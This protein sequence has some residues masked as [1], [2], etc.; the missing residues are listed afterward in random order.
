MSIKD[1]FDEFQDL[2]KKMSKQFEDA[3]RWWED[4]E[5]NIRRK[6]S[7]PMS[8]DIIEEDE[9]FRAIVNLPG[10]NEEDIDIEVT[11]NTLYIQAKHSEEKDEKTDRYIKKERTE[12]SLNRS[13]RLPEKIK[14][15][16]ISAKLKKGVL[17]IDLPKS[18]PKDDEEK[19]EI[20]IE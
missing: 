7:E 5:T 12:K 10:Y 11:D 14:K 13:I 15:D 20:D 9:R 6:L 16:E 18:Q 1:P 17:K 4:E 3:A 2:F 19:I 8:I